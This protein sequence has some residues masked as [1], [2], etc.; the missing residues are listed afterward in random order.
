MQ[1]KFARMILSCSDITFSIGIDDSY[2]STFASL[3]RI[4]N[5]AERKRKARRITKPMKA[6]ILARLP[7]WYKEYVITGTSAEVA[8]AQVYR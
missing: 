2:L 5:E 6:K 4:K 1:G 8:L 3:Y 7:V